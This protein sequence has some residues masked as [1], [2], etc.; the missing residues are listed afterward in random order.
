MKLGMDAAP[1]LN[2]SI[3]SAGNSSPTRRGFLDTLRAARWINAER[4]RVYS[5]I[6]CAC[7][8]VVFLIWLVSRPGGVSATLQ[9]VG[10]D[11]PPYWS[12]S[13]LALEGKPAAIYSH[14]KLYAV[15]KAIL[16]DKDP[17]YQP[18][19]YP[20][21]FLFIVLPL[22]LLPYNFSLIAW[23]LFGVALYLI[24]VRKIASSDDTVWGR[25]HFPAPS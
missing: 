20:P 14:P 23:T 16:G 6:L 10:G 1:K 25:S 7:Y 13:S 22:S 9:P 19:L 17:G 15:E 2:L 18:F 4:V 21:V 24:V 12:A 11:F 8:L 3:G 5:K